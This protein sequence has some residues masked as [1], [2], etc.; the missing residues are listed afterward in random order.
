MNEWMTRDDNALID[1]VAD[2]LGDRDYLF[3]PVFVIIWHLQ[4]DLSHAEIQ[5][6][7]VAIKRCLFLLVGRLISHN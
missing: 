5:L 6:Q 1:D 3:V 7:D 4:T 2:E